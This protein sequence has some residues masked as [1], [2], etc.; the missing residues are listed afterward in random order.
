MNVEWR[1][2]HA[3]IVMALSMSL[4]QAALTSALVDALRSEDPEKLDNALDWWVE[5]THS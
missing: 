2:I 4:D 1:D 5:S 3:T